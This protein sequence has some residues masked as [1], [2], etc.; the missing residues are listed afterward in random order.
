MDPA[1]D[2]NGFTVTVHSDDGHQHATFDCDDEA[3]ARALRNTIREFATSL[4]RVSDYRP[5]RTDR[6]AVAAAK[7]DA[8]TARLELVK[9][10]AS[11]TATA[12]NQA[13]EAVRRALIEFESAHIDTHTPT[14]HRK[15]EYGNAR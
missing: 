3:S 11:S 13:T 9:Q 1:N 8:A 4:R 2:R 10:S 14:G 7:Y 5:S 15:H 12:V 6:Y